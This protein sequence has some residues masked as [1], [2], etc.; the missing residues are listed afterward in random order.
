MKEITKYITD[1]GTEFFSEFNCMRYESQCKRAEELIAQ[2]NVRPKEDTEI[3]QQ[4][5]KVLDDVWEGLMAIAREVVTHKWLEK[6]RQEIH[7]SFP[8]RIIS[9]YGHKGLQEAF[10]RLH[11][12]DSQGREYSQ[13]YYIHKA[14]NQSSQQYHKEKDELIE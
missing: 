2:L 5:I 1:D 12:I 7:I 6:S 14:D 8:A 11:C 13:P 10:Y 3:V 4:D 9:D